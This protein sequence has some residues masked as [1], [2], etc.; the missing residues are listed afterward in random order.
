MVKAGRIM[1]GRPISSRASSA[2]AMPA[3]MSNLSVTRGALMSLVGAVTIVAFGF[4]IPKR[5]MA[6]RNNWRSSAISMASRFAPI[7]ST[8]ATSR[9]DLS[10]ASAPNSSSTASRSAPENSCEIVISSAAKA[11]FNPVCPP[12]VGN[13]A[14]G[15]SLRMILATTAGV[16]GSIYVASA[17]SGSVMIVAGF[18]FTRTTR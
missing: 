18:E 11:V 10:A 2:M 12:M 1:A 8:P 7:I 16:M 3:G 4:S 5:S 13:N 15:R 14:S 9:I 17:M 6:S